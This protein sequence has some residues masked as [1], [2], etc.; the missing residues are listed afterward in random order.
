MKLA[1]V[2][3]QLGAAPDE[4]A[5]WDAVSP[6]WETS[7]ITLPLGPLPFLTE[8]FV[9]RYYPY[10]GFPMEH[11]PTVQEVARRVEASPALRLFIWHAYQRMTHYEEH[12]PF[13]DWPS[14]DGCLDGKGE[15][16][17]LL[18]AIASMPNAETVLR[19]YGLP[20]EIIENTK[21]HL[22]KGARVAP[23][24]LRFSRGS[25]GFIRH[26]VFGRLV[27]VGRMEWLRTRYGG[28]VHVFSHRET[29]KVCFLM[30]GEQLM[31]PC[32]NIVW[33]GIDETEGCWTTTFSANGREFVGCPVNT[34]AGVA[35]QRLV[36]LPRSEWVHRL[37]P[38]MPVL[39]MHIPGG[40][41]MTPEV[42]RE[43]FVG[44][45]E[46]YR[47]YF[48]WYRFEALVCRSWILNPGLQQILPPDANLVRLQRALHLHPV[49]SG[50]TDGLRFLYWGEEKLPESLPEGASS[51]QRAVYD[52]IKAGNRW[53]AAGMVLLP[54]EVEHV[55]LRPLD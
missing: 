21:R 15:L 46:V 44:A 19:Q 3:R 24:F 48:P 17:Y 29:G 26:R 33:E 23:D 18:V 47:R 43:S 4:T 11:L 1:E 35:E 36:T 2:L 12:G 53:R 55:F 37:S 38:G 54:E 30:A 10:T 7:V 32:G 40:G 14:L 6:F 41:A 50:P 51:L 34:R 27:R 9:A 20:D 22:A 25:L 52:Y 28:P 5:L 45:V 42:C 13:G 49:R 31:T 39:E 16:F 8:A